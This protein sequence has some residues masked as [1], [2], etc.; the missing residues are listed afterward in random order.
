MSYL[1]LAK[2]GIATFVM[3][4]GGLVPLYGAAQAQTAVRAPD[5]T[6]S[7]IAEVEGVSHY[8]LPNGMQ[9]L[10][11]P[12]PAKGITTVN[13]TILAGS[14]HENYGESGMAHLLEH[15]IFKGSPKYPEPAMD[16]IRRGLQ[17]NGT[18]S[19]DRTNYFATFSRS[20][21]NF[22]WYLQWLADALVNSNIARKDLD[23][24]MTVVRNEF[25]RGE[26]NAEYMLLERMRSAAF[27]WHNYGKTIIGARSD[28]E[29]VNID[30]LRDFYLRYYQPD[31]AVLIITGSFS[32]ADTLA[33]IQTTFG[34][35]PKPQRQLEPHH[36]LDA[37]Q[38]GE[39]QVTVRRTGN[40]PMVAALYHTMPAAHPDFAAMKLL[41]SIL[42]A[43]P[44]GRIY[45]SLSDKKLATS[46]LGLAFEQREPG[47]I[48]FGA[49]LSAGMSVDAARKDLLAVLDA[50]ANGS[51][52]ITQQELDQAKLLEHAAF[53]QILADP[54]KISFGLSEAAANGDWRLLFLYRD[55][56]EKVQ[57][58]DVRR[59]SKQWLLPDNRTV[60]IYIPTDKPQRAP[61]P[62]F[63]DAQSQLIGYVGRQ[64][65]AGAQAF[66]PELSGLN[67]KVQRFTLTN[68]MK[69]ALLPK[70]SRGDKM[71]AVLT[72][73][74]GTP[75]N[76]APLRAPHILTLGMLDK[77]TQDLSRVALAFKALTLGVSDLGF[78]IGANFIQIAI[79]G[80]GDTISDITPLVVQALRYPAF[81]EDEFEKLK[82]TH[83]A[84]LES[85]RGQP[86][87]VAF[88]ALDQ[89]VN[90]YPADDIR[91]VQNL[92]TQIAQTK[93]TTLQQVKSF[94]EAYFASA[95]VELVLVGT[96]DPALVRQEISRAFGAWRSTAAYAPIQY[97]HQPLEG[98]RTVLATP[99]K[100]S[101]TYVADMPVAMGEQHAD[102]M[103]LRVANFS[104][105]K[106]LL[107]R[108]RNQQGLSYSV[109][110]WLVFHPHDEA[111]HWRIYASFAPQNLDSVETAISDELNQLN[112]KGLSSQ[113]VNEAVA[114]WLEGSKQTR[115]DD[116]SLAYLMGDNLE[117]D[118]NFDWQARLED[119][120]K[121]LT[122]TD[123]NRVI[124]LYLQPQK[125][126]KVVAGDFGPGK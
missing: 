31:N 48:V 104:L 21:E 106:R 45:R 2:H 84:Y 54:V 10:L 86:D 25:E 8:R 99:D 77:G 114:E 27:Q 94:H 97:A 113:E 46:T 57:L 63:M 81:A 89:I 76:L 69:V 11:L 40:I 85:Q 119:Q 74:Y 17:W 28:I 61:E 19:E 16:M 65:L 56:L 29:H 80:R 32:V 95:H 110:S 124:S 9:V 18:T 12:D 78:H 3:V 103:A 88:H 51:D 14:L 13:L 44:Q 126:S 90:A 60:G 35:I 98:S 112:A 125:W 22:T 101:A 26:N 100:K 15:L 39:R 118:R 62:A 122:N 68:G 24:E 107:N 1:K 121:R 109:A 93:S 72:L 120:A 58:E 47:T 115:S 66:D 36:T 123:V 96:F 42:G 59:V 117:K 87:A 52:D 20:D 108:V 30:H 102:Y 91:S 71:R 79:Q 75:D 53:E 7:K 43:E 70:E 23:S 5:S 73:R 64:T 92:D 6:S 41:S 50:P 105:R 49:R 55:R 34:M 82:A 116:K 37:T 111:S 38:D 67:A 83:I 33:Q 4:L